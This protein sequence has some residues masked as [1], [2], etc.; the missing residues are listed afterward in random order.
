LEDGLR[1]L[2]SVAQPILVIGAGARTAPQVIDQALAQGR[3]VTAFLRDPSRLAPRPGLT[4]RAGDIYDLESLASAMTGNEAVVSLVGPKI[5]FSLPENTCVDLYS[6]GTAILITAMRRRGL[7]RLIV[8]SSG[9]VEI[10]PDA[11]PDGTDPVMTWVWKERG[12]Y[13]DM[14]R[15]ET[16]ALNSD[17]DATV[18]RPRSF[19][20]GAMRNDLQTAV[21]VPTPNIASTLTYAD[22]ARFT[23]DEI[24]SGTFRGK[25]V[26]LYTDVMS[27][28]LLA[29]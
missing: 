27:Q 4:V 8:V 22:F 21:D 14:Q 20:D 6:V 10:I 23:L 7:K 29:D 11:K 17:L 19:V 9:G 28:H 18:L 1:G 24:D 26:G 16:I 25:A 3:R 5:D 12:L 15:M 13:Q 2:L